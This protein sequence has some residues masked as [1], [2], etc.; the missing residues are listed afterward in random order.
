MRGWGAKIIWGALIV[1]FV[2]GAFAGFG[3]MSSG[4]GRG[5]TAS[6]GAPSVVARVNGEK[7]LRD[8]FNQ[9][10]AWQLRNASMFGGGESVTS[11]ISTKEQALE[12]LIDSSVKLQA[13][14]RERI[15]VRGRDIDD[16]V[17]KMATD[18]LR[19]AQMQTSSPKLFEREIRKKFGYVRGTGRNRR[20]W[21]HTCLFQ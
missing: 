1:I 15:R 17:E 4:G 11:F 12:Q 16:E 18:A 3:R 19:N 5:S 2:V 14:K 21:I 20:V 13:S 8:Q 6:G 7:I 9:V 10:V